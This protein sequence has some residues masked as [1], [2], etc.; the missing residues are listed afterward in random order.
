MKI[1]VRSKQSS[2]EFEC[3]AQQRILYAG[4]S[5]GVPLPYECGTGTCGTC[6]ARARPGTVEEQWADAP[7]RSYLKEERGEFL[8]CQAQPLA[9]C[10]ILVPTPSAPPPPRTQR[11]GDNRGRLSG[12]ERLTD[13]V[14]AFSVD[15]EEPMAFLP[16]QFALVEAPGLRGFR[17]YSM[18]NQAGSAQR[19]DFVIKRKP[20]GRFSDWLFDRARENAL[21]QVFGPLGR[22]IFYPEEGKHLLTIA[23]GSGIAGI[24]SM[25]ASACDS[26][27]FSRHHANVFFGVRTRQDVFYLD[28]LAAYA[29]R[30]AGRLR[31]VIALSDEEEAE[32]LP[33]PAPDIRYDSGFVHLCAAKHMAG[34][35]ADTVAFVAGPPPMVDGA[36]RMLVIDGKLPAGDI[37]YDK[38]G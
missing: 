27:F 4:L 37:R 1:K 11:P 19:L 13:D 34:A 29:R 36:L 15:L 12:L 32:A 14:A 2:F 35:F 18:V 22:A 9:D 23:G 21:M 33:P 24:M 17:A 20:G 8:M 31:V 5:A 7:G 10:E 26:D 25:L 28:E 30:A 3:G 16:G 38:F 6:K